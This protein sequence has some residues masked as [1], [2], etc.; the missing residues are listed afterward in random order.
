MMARVT[1]VLLVG[2]HHPLMG[3]MASLL[4]GNRAFR[5]RE[6]LP[7]MEFL[8]EALRASSR[9]IV[10]MDVDLATPD[11]VA[12][13]WRWLKRFS[14]VILI[15]VSGSIDDRLVSEAFQAGAE[16]LL[17]KYSLADTLLPALTEV[18]AGGSCFPGD[19]YGRVEIGADGP[20]LQTIDHPSC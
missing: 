15:L 14:G 1:D 6:V 18:L 19:V 17:D 7:S 2:H 20:R 8:P 4:D 16:G 3:Y 11:W 5:V 13:S 9:T 12:C 10:L